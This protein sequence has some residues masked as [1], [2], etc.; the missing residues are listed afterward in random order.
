[1]EGFFFVGTSFM[2]H[3]FFIFFSLFSCLSNAMESSDQTFL[4]DLVNLNSSSHSIEGCDR[5]RQRISQEAKKLGLNV[6]TF[7]LQEKRKILMIEAQDAQPEILF[8]GHVD[9]VFSKDSSFQKAT[10]LKEKIK[11]PGVIDMKSGIVLMFSIL[12]KLSPQNRKKVR[13]LLNDDEELGSF[14]SQKKLRELSRGIPYG[15]VFE[16]GLADGSFVQSHSGVFWFEVDVKGKA[17][18][19]GNH[20]ERGVNACLQLSQWIQEI[21]KLENP[22]KKLTINVGK[23]EGGNQT[24]VVCENAKAFFDLRYVDPRDLESFKKQLHITL[25]TKTVFSDKKESVSVQWRHLVS[26]HSM[27]SSASEKIVSVA[28]KLAKKNH[29][30]FRATHVGYASDANHLSTLGI[31][32]LVGVGPY[33]GHM[34]HSEEFMKISSYDSRLKFVTALVQKLLF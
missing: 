34:H 27:P 7:E 21:Q 8:I 3:L 6:R 30:D 5:V 28:K 1:M 20:P 33:G 17:A 25:K 10:L 4:I 18:H 14:I 19:A 29:F 13:I 9:T 16:P 12:K 11:G 15:L 26:I 22:K 23:I 31:S 24:N 32:L 2:N